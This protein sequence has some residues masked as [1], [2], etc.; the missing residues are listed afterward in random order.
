MKQITL[1]VF[2]A[3]ML[4]SCSKDKTTTSSNPDPTPIKTPLELLDG[5]WKIESSISNEAGNPSTLPDC[6]KDNLVTFNSNGSM[7]ADEGAVKCDSMDAQTST[8]TWKMA[9]YPTL[10][11]K[12]DASTQFTTV[13]IIQLDETYLKYEMPVDTR[14][15]TLTWKRK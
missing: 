9:N 3:L 8:G 5:T 11:F 7:L 6:S 12:Q 10:E 4:H 14:T 15:F 13:K 2:A 1:L